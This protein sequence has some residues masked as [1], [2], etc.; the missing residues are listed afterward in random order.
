ML[1]EN[2]DNWNRIIQE[3]RGFIYNDFGTQFPGDSPTWN[4]RDNNK[5]HH[6]SCFHVKKMTHI[7]EGKLTKHFFKTKR[8]AIDWLKENRSE[9]GYSFCTYCKP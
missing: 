9:E 3:G 7:T 5:L 2:I 6:V 1:I 8:E 4:T